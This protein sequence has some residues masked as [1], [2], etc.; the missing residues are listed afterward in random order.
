MGNYL[1]S[2]SSRASRRILL[3]IA[4]VP[5]SF[6]AA[7]ISSLPLHASDESLSGPA[8]GIVAV[9]DES[10]KTVYVTSENPKPRVSAPAIRRRDTGLV[11]WSAKQRKWKP[12]LVQ[13]ASVMSAARSAATEV[14][15]YVESKPKSAKPAMTTRDPNYR[16]LARGYQVSSADIDGAI[17]TAARRHNVDPN[18]IRAIIK[19]ESNFNPNAISRKGAMGLM[20]LMPGTARSLNVQNPFDPKQNVEAGVRYFKNLMDNYRGDLKLSLAAYN[21]GA[22][23]VARSNGIPHIPETQNYVKQITQMYWSGKQGF[24]SSVASYSAPIRVFRDAHGVLTM[25]NDD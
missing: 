15:S 12:I 9:R 19:T 7:L 17:E 25:T 3:S 1:K 11:Y 13:S 10:G 2:R 16:N 18:L 6:A 22:G 23:A 8:Y 5:F 20:Q 14:A 24:S 4:L 21:A